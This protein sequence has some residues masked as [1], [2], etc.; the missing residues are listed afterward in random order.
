VVA[1]RYGLRWRA[2]YHIIGKGW[3]CRSVGLRVF[4]T[5]EKMAD[6]GPLTRIRRDRVFAGEAARAA[7]VA[8]EADDQAVTVTAGEDPEWVPVQFP[9]LLLEEMPTGD[10]R[11]ID[12][13]AVT[14]G[15][16]P[17]PVFVDHTEVGRV[18]TLTRTVGVT[19]RPDGSTFP[20]GVAVW[21]ATGAIYGYTQPEV[22][23]MTTKLF[24]EADLFGIGVS[25]VD[26][27]LRIGSG[28]LVSVHL[29]ELPAFADACWSLDL[30]REWA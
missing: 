21:S 6:R 1:D 4:L 26:G 25:E 27:A 30:P 7:R 5:G 10:G 18:D 24:P 16:L 8:G 2:D 3:F 13:H 28:V 15:A 22:E 17:L 23:A 14:A 29:G 9:V 12:R 11:I 20:D 19:R